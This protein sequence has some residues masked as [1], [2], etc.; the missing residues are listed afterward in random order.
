MAKPRLKPSGKWEIGLRHPSLPKGRKYFVFDTEVEAIAYAQQWKLMKHADIPPPAELTT[1][2]SPGDGVRLARILGEWSDSGFAAPTQLLTLKT[3][4]RE[5]GSV[6]FSEANYKWLTGYLRFLKVEKNLSPTSIKHRIQALSRAIDE[7]LRHNVSVRI[8]NPVKLLPKGYSTYSDVDAQMVKAKGGK[9][10][11]SEARDRRLLPGEHEKI[12]AV[13]SGYERP[14]RARGLELKGG[15]A[16]LTLYL[17]ILNTGLRL[18]EAYTLTRGQIDMENKVIHVKETK[19]WRG[20]ISFRDVPMRPEVHR[21]LLSYF[22]SRPPFEHG[23]LLFPFLEEEGVEEGKK[24]LTR[25]GQRLSF[26]FR[27]AFEYMD[28]VGLHE[29]DLRH[30]ATCR[31]LELKDADGRDMFRLEELNKIM[32]WKPGSMMAQRYASFRGVDLAQRL[33]SVPEAVEASAAAA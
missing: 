7:Y 19:Q 11:V 32:G 14:D 5:V 31:W 22:A 10:K 2:T 30:E 3:L 15:D 9:V 8:G 26:R 18:R 27:I 21:A 13:L 23:T 28:I 25:A 4:T 33:W 16:L 20:K 17:L 6:R 1:P 12:V 24:G 29:H